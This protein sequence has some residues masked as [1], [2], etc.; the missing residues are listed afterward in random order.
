MKQSL[1]I[2][3][4]K[5]LKF[6]ENINLNREKWDLCVQKSINRKVYVLS[7]YLDIVT[8]RWDALVYGDYELIFPIVSK[9]RFCLKFMFQPL[10]CQQLGPFSPYKELLYNSE[11]IYSIWNFIFQRFRLFTFSTN[12][13]VSEFF[14]NSDFFKKKMNISVSN[15][16]NLELDLSKNYNQLRAH[17]SNNTKRNL[18][19]IT[20]RTRKGFIT[21]NDYCIKT[22]N[23]VPEFITF[24]QNNLHQKVNL[25]NN[26]YTIMLNLISTCLNKKTGTPAFYTVAASVTEVAGS[27]LGL[28]D[29]KNQLL[30]SV[31]F[32]HVFNRHILLFNVSKI[33]SDISLMT[34]LIDQY[35]QTNCRTQTEVLNKSNNPYGHCNI[36]P[37]LDFEGSNI[38]GVKR[39]YQGFG[40][41]EKNYNLFTRRF[42]N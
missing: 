11:V 14:K 32:L 5:K 31:F 7:W 40:A 10:F 25:K 27:L 38:T 1:G 4:M 29:T 41:V 2:F 35:I 3:Y 6:I 37:I 42:F 21:T 30:A 33:G 24:F 23:D 26:D 28:Y 36:N 9:S 18:G 13:H 39:F 8:D 15:R 16:I 12:Y 19:R 17:Y 22:M 34:Y 20:S